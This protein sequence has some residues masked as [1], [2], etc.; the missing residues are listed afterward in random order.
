MF[1]YKKLREIIKLNE[2]ERIPLE[3]RNKLINNDKLEVQDLVPNPILIRNKNNIDIVNK[4]A[5][6]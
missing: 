4:K 6:T 2:Y 3:T 1:N 5:L